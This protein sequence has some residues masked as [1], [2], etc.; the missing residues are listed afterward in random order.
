MLLT[1]VSRAKGSLI[2]E[3]GISRIAA[4]KSNYEDRS[5]LRIKQI[6]CV[7]KAREYLTKKKIL[8]D[9]CIVRIRDLQCSR[10]RLGHLRGFCKKIVNIVYENPHGRPDCPLIKDHM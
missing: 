3:L 6:N 5:A 1:S 7:S 9:A 8:T 2:L 4:S 10:I